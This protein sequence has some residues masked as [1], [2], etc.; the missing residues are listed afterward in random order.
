[1]EAA[2]PGSVPQ[3]TSTPGARAA[4]RSNSA[5]ISEPATSTGRQPTVIRPKV[6]LGP[7]KQ[8]LRYCSAP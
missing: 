3:I 5:S 4:A 7:A 2:A 8:P 6:P 1:M